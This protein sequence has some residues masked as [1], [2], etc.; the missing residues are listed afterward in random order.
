[1]PVNIDITIT[2]NR[3]DIFNKYSVNSSRKLIDMSIPTDRIIALK[4][5]IKNN[6]NNKHIDLELEIQRMW[7]M[8]TE[9][10]PVVVGA[11]GT[12]KKGMVENIKRVSERATVTETQKIIMLGSARILRK[13]LKCMIKMN[14]L[15]V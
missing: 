7:Q 1:M 8:K 11:L 5:I 3:S 2:T 13:A 14:D 6:N 15:C 10:I 4:E 12:I 9:V